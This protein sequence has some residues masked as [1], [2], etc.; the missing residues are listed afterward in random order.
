MTIDILKHNLLFSC[1]VLHSYSINGD[2]TGSKVSHSRCAALVHITG[3]FD[4]TILTRV[5]EFH[6]NIVY[7]HETAVRDNS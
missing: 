3:C 4:D 2:V 5:T 6:T 7:L 1:C